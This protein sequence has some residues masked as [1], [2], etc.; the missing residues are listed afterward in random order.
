MLDKSG[1]LWC[2]PD[3][4]V[5][6]SQTVV[7]P[8]NPGN[9]EKVV[10]PRGLIS[11]YHAVEQSAGPA[12]GS[13]GATAGAAGPHNKAVGK[14]PGYD[15]LTDVD[16]EDEDGA[17]D[18]DEELDE[19]ARAARLAKRAKRRQ[20]LAAKRDKLALR[21]RKA[22][23][24]EILLARRAVRRLLAWLPA[25]MVPVG[26]VLPVSLGSHSDI[27]VRP[28]CNVAC[29]WSIE[30]WVLL[31]FERDLAAMMAADDDDEDDGMGEYGGG[32]GMGFGEG[33]F[34][35][36][37]QAGAGKEEAEEQGGIGK[38]VVLMRRLEPTVS[39]MQKGKALLEA[40][41]T[42]AAASK[43]S[44]ASASAATVSPKDPKKAL[45]SMHPRLSVAWELFLTG[46]GEIGFRC[47]RPP[48]SPKESA[49]A[50][51]RRSRVQQAQAGA[52]KEK[53]KGATEASEDEEPFVT[54]I[55]NGKP[56]RDPSLP[57]APQEEASD[58]LQKSAVQAGGWVHVAVV[59]DATP[60]SGE[61]S[62][63]AGARAVGGFRPGDGTIKMYVDFKECGKGAV[64]CG[65]PLGR[66]DWA[67]KAGKLLEEGAGAA[68]SGGA[69]GVGSAA[70]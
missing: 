38:E 17:D 50:A 60:V 2:R 6:A 41:K 11:N 53:K 54:L 39:S 55:G 45:K 7:T 31:G 69:D 56:S 44:A 35:G 19:K 57:R 14:V 5:Y 18:S 42:G 23:S 64:R 49:G 3:A 59:F 20:A 63:E 51:S 40:S 8:F 1:A 70:R 28:W 9:P 15:S 13:S 36:G 46:K 32:D 12:E 25:S 22:A 68:G 29:T 48:V 58:D 67:V 61:S 34:G 10:M 62:S 16:D 30:A 26:A 52:D 66:P 65:T 27:G 43:S 21:A 4:G 33:G 47:R 24:K 37:D